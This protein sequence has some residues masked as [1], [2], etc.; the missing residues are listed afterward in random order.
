[1]AASIH[2]CVCV[3]VDSSIVDVTYSCNVV[4]FALCRLLNDLLCVEWDVKPCVLTRVYSHE[5]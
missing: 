3:K 1:M 4:M 2:M 5:Q